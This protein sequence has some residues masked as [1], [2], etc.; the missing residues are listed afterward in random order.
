MENTRKLQKK[1]KNTKKGKLTKW[2]IIVYGKLENWKE[3]VTKMENTKTKLEKWKK[4]KIKKNGKFKKNRKL[5]KWQTVKVY[6]RY[7]LCGNF[8][9]KYEKA[10]NLF[11]P[12][13]F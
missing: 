12:W 1:Y 4:W 2:K 3:N 6:R 7:K 13:I 9:L 8:A 5:K 10:E 11:F